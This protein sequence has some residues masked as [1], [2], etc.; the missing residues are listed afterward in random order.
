MNFHIFPSVRIQ[1]CAIPQL[2]SVPLNLSLVEELFCFLAITLRTSED[3]CWNDTKRQVK[4]FF[5]FQRRVYALSSQYLLFVSSL[6]EEHLRRSNSS[7][8]LPSP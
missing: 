6:F 3:V 8:A 2:V 7:T 1:I 4:V 5:S